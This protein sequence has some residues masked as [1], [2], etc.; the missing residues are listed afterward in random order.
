MDG[1]MSKGANAAVGERI[2]NNIKGYVLYIVI[3]LV[4]LGIFSGAENLLHQNAGLFQ[5]GELVDLNECIASGKELPLN[6]FGRL[7]LKAVAGSYASYTTSNES[8]F[9]MKF[10]SGV[11]YYYLVLLEDMRVMTVVV[12]NPQDIAALDEL[13]AAV[14]AYE[15]DAGIFSEPDF[16][17]HT[18]T[19]KLKTMTDEEMI[20]YYQDAVRQAGLSPLQFNVTMLELDTTAIRAEKALLILGAPIALIAIVV[21]VLVRRSKRRRQEQEEYQRRMAER[22]EAGL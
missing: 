2:K 11:D 21:L 10:Q 1:F 3:G 15:G 8:R 14:E 22:E 12:S 20:G 9:G 13:V 4:V 19:G 5:G 17:S 6:E 16:P 7:E 18:F